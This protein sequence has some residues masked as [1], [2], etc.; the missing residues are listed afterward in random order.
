M[1]ID[2][3]FDD[4]FFEAFR[5]EF[6]GKVKKLGYRFQAL[7]YP[8][9]ENLNINLESNSWLK[10]IGFIEKNFNITGSKKKK[11]AIEELFK[12]GF[13]YNGVKYNVNVA[14]TLYTRLL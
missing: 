3:K 1:T 8:Q 4:G 5:D 10:K 9:S 14:Y 6:S 12:D 13:D 7:A 11:E 2:R